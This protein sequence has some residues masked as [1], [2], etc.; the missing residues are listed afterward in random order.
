[1]SVQTCQVLSM[2]A[3]Q[4]AA[5]MRFFN[6]MPE[7][8][9]CTVRI[10]NRNEY[11][12]LH[13]ADASLAAKE[14]FKS[15]SSVKHMTCGQN[16][17]EYVILNQNHYEALLRTLL[18]NKTYR[19]E[20]YCSPN[21]SSNNWT[22]EYKAS[23]GNLY[24]FEDLLF[25]T[26][27]E[28]QSG[29]AAIKIAG[30]GKSKIVGV[31]F[32]E[33]SNSKMRVAQFPDL[34]NLS[35]MECVIQ[36]LAP[37]ELLVSSGM[38]DKDISAI[39]QFAEHCGMLVTIRPKNT[40]KSD[41]AFV[42]DMGRLLRLKPGQ[43]DNVAAL[44]EMKLTTATQALSACIN[45]LEL[46]SDNGNFKQFEISEYSS[47]L[48]VRIDVQTVRAIN[49]KPG[50]GTSGLGKPHESIVGLLGQAVCTPH[51]QRLLLKWLQQPL[52][53]IAPLQERLDCVEALNSDLAAMDSLSKDYLKGIPDLQYLARKIHRKKANLQDLY[54]I[55]QG[56][57]RLSGVVSLLEGLSNSEKVL[58]SVKA[59]LLEPLKEKN[60]DMA[61]Y[62]EMVEQTLDIDLASQGEFLIRQEFDDNLKE[63]QSRR[64]EMKE[65]MES[66][67]FSASRELDLEAN[68]SM[69]LEYTAQ[70]GYFYRITLKDEK[71]LRGNK[72][73]TIIDT[74]KAG[75]RFTNQKLRGLNE[76]YQ[77]ASEEY[78]KTQQEIVQGV[79]DVA[80]TY[81]DTINALGDVLA[82]ID[83]LNSFAVAASSSSEPYC[84]P[85]LHPPGSGVLKFKQ[86]RHPCLERQ[87]GVDYVAN[88]AVFD[89]EK[90]RLVILTG[91]NMG[92]KSTYI[93]SVAA[94][95]V[96][97]QLGAFV[98]AA[99]AALSLVDSVL[100]RIGAGDSMALGVSTF[101]AEMLET[102]TI[103]KAA[104]NRS[105]VIIDELGR[106][107]STYDGFG[108]AWA[109]SEN[110]AKDV[111][112]FCLFATHF[113]ELTAL[114]HQ[115]PGVVNRH[116][117][118]KTSEGVLTLM[119]RIKDGPCDQS[120]GLHVAQMTE[121]PEQVLQRAAEKQKQ[122]E[123][124]HKWV[125]SEFLTQEDEDKKKGEELVEEF[126]E[127]VKALDLD[128]PEVLCRKL[129]ELQQKISSSDNDFLKTLVDSF[130][131]M[132]S[133]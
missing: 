13:G 106:G 57:R 80:A 49:L 132:Q 14:I 100:V 103:L 92:G 37:R 112:C 79:V 28:L 11:Y 82:T 108:L 50:V 70:H 10:F 114:A 55:Y 40:F 53:N 130:V 93:R 31:G 27:S 33:S 62:V 73:F 101:M 24:Q 22:I 89:Q 26:K 19:V 65:E 83:V 6:T 18:L 59:L 54:R 68:K 97:A 67:L 110:I 20:V 58:S 91:P 77:E 78:Q 63:I 32:V 45:F 47:E 42:Q 117:V 120:F 116:V 88:D 74:N 75:I 35:N 104:T 56:V 76:N 15:T 30:D 122:L 4:Q 125:P 51:G 131:P 111:G 129:E 12:T 107:T 38:D 109:I 9:A 1:M 71:I 105:L 90:E 95:V 39:K 124:L 128:D 41:D 85:L 81:S 17:L 25:N 5:F 66:A 52:R 44:P 8:S 133:S 34:D 43:S 99:E 21:N 98:P 64:S 127:N 94:A 119:Y 2:D 113:H 60:A 118:A 126:L 36:Q 48:F 102:S 23:P 96:M 86:L 123:L 69:K 29:I 72:K 87:N 3:S 16:Q 46:V 115:V 61:N 121:F 84:R 7:K